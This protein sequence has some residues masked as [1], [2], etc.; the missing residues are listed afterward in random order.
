MVKE[1]R[2]KGKVCN[3]F[4]QSWC[5][6]PRQ[7]L[8]I[9]F[10]SSNFFSSFWQALRLPTA[11]GISHCLNSGGLGTLPNAVVLD[12]RASYG[13]S[14]GPFSGIW[15]SVEDW[16][17]SPDVFTTPEERLATAFPVFQG[18]CGALPIMISLQW[19]WPIRDL[20]HLRSEIV[21]YQA[22]A[23][24]GF[25]VSFVG[26]LCGAETSWLLS[27]LCVRGVGWVMI[28]TLTHMRVR[29]Q[30]AM[31][32]G[33]QV[34]CNDPKESNEEIMSTLCICVK[35]ETLVSTSKGLTVRCV[36]YLP[37]ACPACPSSTCCIWAT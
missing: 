34:T 5:H 8:R 36:F 29:V 11:W 30:L 20:I 28:K 23:F 2:W 35:R 33:S 24:M 14:P 13:Q 1:M 31:W 15:G 37:A 6:S 26:I 16:E 17:H 27:L 22:V 32:F 10:Y 21:L 4:H 7:T 18:L 19:F 9:F 3:W 12:W 25:Q